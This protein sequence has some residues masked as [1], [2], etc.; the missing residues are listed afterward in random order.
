MGRRIS[1]TPSGIGQCHCAGM[2]QFADEREE[3]GKSMVPAAAGVG[4]WRPGVAVHLQFATGWGEFNGNSA[5]KVVHDTGAAEFFYGG[6][7]RLAGQAGA[8][9]EF[10]P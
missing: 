8:K 4:G 3:F 5:F 10:R 6:T 7:R 9:E 1:G 2:A